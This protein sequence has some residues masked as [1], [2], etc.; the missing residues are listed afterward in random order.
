MKR[1]KAALVILIIGIVILILTPVFKWVIGPT[2]VKIPDNINTTSVYEGTLTLFV[3][4][5]TLQVLPPDTPVKIPLAITR[6][7]V[8]QPSKSN[9]NVAVV[10][11]TV[12]AV[13]PAGKTFLSWTKYYAMDRKKSI[14]VSGNNSD[15]NRQ[16]YFILLP[17]FLQKKTYQMWDDDTAKLG[18]AKFV[19]VKKIDGVK[20]KGITAYVYKVAG[21][22][23]T[24]TPPLGLPKTISG[25]EVKSILGNPNFAVTDTQQYP[26]TYIKR[27]EATIVA[28]QKT[29]TIV[30]LP[31]Y[32]E[33]YYVDASTLGQGN[34]KI[35]AL[36]YAQTPENV[37]QVIDDCAKYHNQ[38]DLATTWIPLIMLILGVV[39]TVIGAIWFARK[40]PA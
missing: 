20:Y 33:T 5:T 27:T 35:G 29:G 9:G 17:F 40:K 23:P 34:I 6:K 2:L 38:I 25:A 15:T 36:H 11:E 14:N 13:G 26:I 7:D 32:N 30:D 22:D 8:S 3:D 31:D 10:K 37:A 21:Q 4:P 24:I 18:D 28:D 19:A 39:L 12:A 1:S 16:G